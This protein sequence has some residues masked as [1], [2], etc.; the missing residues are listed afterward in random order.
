MIG[1]RVATQTSAA[2]HMR[3]NRGLNVNICQNKP[4]VFGANTM[5]GVRRA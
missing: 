4:T 5:C 2:I 3:N 1:G